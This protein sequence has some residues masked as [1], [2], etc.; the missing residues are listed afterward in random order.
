V[1]TLQKLEEYRLQNKIS[2]M[3]LAR[4]LGVAFATINRWLNGRCKPGKIQ[5]Y[6]LEKFLKKKSAGFKSLKRSLFKNRS[7]A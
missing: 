1:E 5:Q 3:D 7:G 4:E 6:H 2:Q